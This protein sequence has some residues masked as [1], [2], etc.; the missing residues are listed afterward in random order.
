MII[1]LPYF[2][3]SITETRACIKFAEQFALLMGP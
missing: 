2:Y 1:P 3:W